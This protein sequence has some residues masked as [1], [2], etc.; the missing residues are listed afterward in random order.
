MARRLENIGDAVMC[1]ERPNPS[2]VI[3]DKFGHDQLDII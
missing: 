1:R 2:S 3:I